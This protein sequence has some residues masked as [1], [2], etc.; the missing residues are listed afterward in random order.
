MQLGTFQ[1]GL[2]LKNK[3]LDLTKQIKA[4]TAWIDKLEGTDKG[5]C[6]ETSS[7]VYE[8]QNR[9]SISYRAYYRVDRQRFAAFLKNEQKILE[10]DLRETERQFE[11]LKDI[12]PKPEKKK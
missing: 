10:R 6:P 7:D 1:K 4:C 11:K 2:E 12:E 9:G 5:N 3:A 8:E